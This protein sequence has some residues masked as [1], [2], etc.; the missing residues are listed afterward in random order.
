M[1]D[2]ALNIIQFLF[3]DNGS[4]GFV[5]FAEDSISINVRSDSSVY[6]GLLKRYIGI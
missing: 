4:S 3:T 6:T 5:T 1:T 2:I